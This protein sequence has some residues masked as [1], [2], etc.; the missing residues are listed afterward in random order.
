MVL[1]KT[2]Y[3]QEQISFKFEQNVFFKKLH[4]DFYI[5]KRTSP[6]MPFNTRNLLLF[7][8]GIKRKRME[9]LNHMEEEIKQYELQNKEYRSSISRLRIAHETSPGKNET[10]SIQKGKSSSLP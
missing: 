5:Q 1:R 2:D 10:V 3:K 8:S 4:F 7:H 6:G 9:Y